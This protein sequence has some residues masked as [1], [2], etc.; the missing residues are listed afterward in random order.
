[1]LL[2]R[3]L[4]LGVHA[5]DVLESLSFYKALGFSELPIGDVL[6]HKYAVISDGDIRIGLHERVFDSPAVTFVHQDLARHARTMADHGCDFSF[7]R[8]DEDVFNELGF[9]DRDGNMIRMIEARTF[10]PASEEEDHSLCGGFLELTLPV[11]DAL[12]AG[13]FWA[14]F[15][16]AVLRVRE[17]P[18]T[19]MRF[20]A[21]GI[22]LGVSESIALP[23]PALSFKCR[24]KT[25]LNAAVERHG[26]RVQTFPGFEGAFAVL[27]APEG[28]PL[29]V[30]E[31]DFLG[32]PYVVD[33]SGEPPPADT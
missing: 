7:L 21:G 32:E 10:S 8:I 31:E 29:F 25:A 15:G 17:E 9:T 26:W 28:T 18:T 22:A 6:P 24:D 11:R 5:P 2:G 20:D 4:E 3:F 30:F 12:R 33:E 23:G 1:M 19:H 16:P 27:T 13:R 14:P